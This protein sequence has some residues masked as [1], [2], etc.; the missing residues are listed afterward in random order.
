[1]E[2]IGGELTDEEW[3]DVENEQEEN[4][5]DENGIRDMNVV[6]I[7]EEHQNVHEIEA[8]GDST[9]AAASSSVQKNETASLDPKNQ[10]RF[11]M[12]E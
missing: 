10:S 12:S 8:T 11:R 6:D 4:N 2:I 7:V 3:A 1:M 5:L 9:D